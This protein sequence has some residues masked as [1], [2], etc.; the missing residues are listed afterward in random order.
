MTV[1]RSN[2][3]FDTYALYIFSIR[4][5]PLEE[6]H[7]SVRLVPATAQAQ[8][9]HRTSLIAETD[10]SLA[11][12]GLLGYWIMSLFWQTSLKH[13]LKI[14]RNLGRS[15]GIAVLAR[16]IIHSESSLL[17]KLHHVVVDF[18]FYNLV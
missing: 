11:M 18:Y 5:P 14:S 9:Q 16:H 12:I 7:S 2:I 1:Q 13:S 4:H 6:I 8:H 3:I 15:T 17:I 10:I